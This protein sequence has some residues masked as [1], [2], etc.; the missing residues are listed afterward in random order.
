[1]GQFVYGKHPAFGDFLTAGLS[2]VA[3]DRIEV[4]LNA[5]LSTLKAA[6]GTA[7]EQ[8]FDA[9]PTIA[10]WLGAR[11]TGSAAVRGAMIPSQDKVGRRFPLLA[12]HEG[13]GPLPPAV[14]PTDTWCADL[15]ALLPDLSPDPTKGAQGIVEMLPVIAGED[16]DADPAF[17]AARD[18][19]DLAQLWA[20]VA[21]ADHLRAAHARSYWWVTG[22]PTSLYATEGF[23][24]AEALAWLMA[25]GRPLDQQSNP[26]PGDMS[27]ASTDNHA[28]PTAVEVE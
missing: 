3:Q 9:S 10:F 15:A 6:W 5:S 17:W 13:P 12:G 7:W 21:F 1:M 2:G 23:P 4:W 26:Q 24:P 27:E 8:G 22:S 28:A 14:D 25:G 20:D 18:D 11:V 19:G 16:V